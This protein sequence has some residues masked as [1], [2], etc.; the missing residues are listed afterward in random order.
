MFADGSH[1]S[2][3]DET[4]LQEVTQAPQPALAN[5]RRSL[6]APHAEVRKRRGSGFLIVFSV[7]PAKR[8]QRLPALFVHHIPAAKE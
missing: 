6:Q 8:N 3:S 5:A 1:S 2:E 4:H 7:A